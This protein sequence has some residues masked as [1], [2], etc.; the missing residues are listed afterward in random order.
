M[1]EKHVNAKYRVKS[2]VNLLEA[3]IIEPCEQ[4]YRISEIGAAFLSILVK[5]IKGSLFAEGFDKF[6][7]EGYLKWREEKDNSIET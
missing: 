7:V 4:G 3:G 5:M 2:V 6:V 1:R